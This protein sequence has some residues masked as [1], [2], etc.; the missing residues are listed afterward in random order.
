TPLQLVRVLLGLEPEIPDG[1]LSL[2]P[3]WPE[4][5]GPLTIHDLQLAGVS[6]ALSVDSGGARISGLPAAISV[7]S[8][9]SRSSSPR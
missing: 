5:F 8:G 7:V 1:R 2:S 9:P 3:A 4:S 6:A